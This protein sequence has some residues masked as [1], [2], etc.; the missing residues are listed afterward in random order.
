MV[1]ALSARAQGEE[2]CERGTLF[3]A[4]GQWFFGHRPKQTL[5]GASV[6]SLHAVISAL[7]QVCGLLGAA[8]SCHCLD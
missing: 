4:M 8:I 1:P 2:K 5:G 7:S 6:A 3:L